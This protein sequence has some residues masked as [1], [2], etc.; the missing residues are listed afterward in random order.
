MMH[1]SLLRKISVVGVSA[2]CCLALAGCSGTNYGYTGGVAAT[3]NG[4]EIQEDT[5]TKYIQDFRTSSD[6]TSDDDW[7]NW[8]SENSFD[9]ST[10]RDQVVDYY[11]EI[12]LKKQACEEKGITVDDSQVDEQIDKIKANYDSDD[13]WKEALSSAGLTEDQYRESVAAGLRDQALEEAVA[14]DSA[15]ADDA[16]VL[17]MLNTYYTMFNG[18]KKS[19]H[20]LF[21][22]SDTEKAQEVLDQI[23]AGT[24][25]F[26]EAAKQ[27]STDTTSAEDGGNVGWDCINNFVTEYTDALDNLSKDQVSGLVT[28][29]YGIHI[30][31]CTDEFTTDGT[32][33]DLSAYPSEFVDYISKIIK[34]QNESSAYSTWFSDYKSQADI[35]N[36]DMPEKVPYNLDMTKYESS[37]DSS[38]DSSDSSSSDSSSSDTSA[39]TESSSSSS[40]SSESTESTETSSN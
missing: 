2:A 30:I 15:T 3:V 1:G 28:S 33:T 23:N 12:E 7:G 34:S 21:A 20:I 17:N 37:S 19:S 38:S 29:D 6:L 35:Q 25:D 32:A 11:V 8:M 36:N 14:G 24:L 10:V 22:S 31:K 4:S 9:P 18:A 5:I 26:A 13:A 27:Y 39:T 16:S 40:E